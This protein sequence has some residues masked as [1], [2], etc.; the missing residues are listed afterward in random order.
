MTEHPP[1]PSHSESPGIRSGTAAFIRV[2]IALFLGG[3]STF[4]LVYCV[5]PLLPLFSH[6]YGVS[7]AQA[8]IMLSTTTGTMSVMLIVASVLSDRFGRRGIMI[9]SLLTGALLM[10][11]CAVIDHF[12]TLFVLRTLQGIALAGLPAVAMAYLA[13]EIEFSALG[14]AMGF[15]I[16]GN[17]LGGMSGRLITAWVAEHSSWQM[18]LATIGVLALLMALG[19][20]KLLPPSR[21]FKPRPLQLAVMWEGARTHFRDARL[22]WLF[23]VAFLVMGSFISVYNYLAFRLALSPFSLSTGQIGS[24]FLLYIIGMFS[25]T[26]VGR[27][28]DRFGLSRVLWV[29][30]T[31]MLGGVLLTLVET[32]WVVIVGV[33]ILTF[34][35]F[36]SHAVAS[37]WVGRRA[38]TARGLASALYLWAYYFGSSII[39]T[40]SGTLWGV[41]GWNAIVACLTTCLA[42]CLAV[43][44]YLRRA[45]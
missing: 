39:G 40:F 31:L 12:Q 14:Y 41:G 4:S 7:P 37:S 5:Q 38:K 6:D 17:A 45:E 44:V 23:L 24:V 35:F 20:W 42:L 32:L 34:G 15:Y 36:S 43:A 29:V 10:V 16:S 11:A 1:S 19:F 26:W 3:F 18:A 25:S 28:A 13:E 8:S 21:H 27:L 2:Q 22:P 30:V 9:F 33:A